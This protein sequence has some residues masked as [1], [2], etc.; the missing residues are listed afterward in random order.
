MVLVVR[1]QGGQVLDEKNV[2][3]VYHKD[4]DLPVP[5]FSIQAVEEN[6]E[7]FIQVS[8]NKLACNVMFYIPG[9]STFFSDNYIDIIPGR[10]YKIKV[11]TD[12][13]PAQI[14]ERIRLHYMY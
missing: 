9:V 1:L 8:S 13:S 14:R 10:S 7:K 3:C 4:L 11:E 12:L 5:H 2:Y 6:G